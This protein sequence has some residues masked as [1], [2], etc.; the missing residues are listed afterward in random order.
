MDDFWAL[1]LAFLSDICNHLNQ[2]NCQ[3]Q[4]KDILF[5]ESFSKLQAFRRK[6]LL[7]KNQFENNDYTNFP[8]FSKASAPEELDMGFFINIFDKLIEE[9][10]SRFEDDLTE[11]FQT[12]SQFVSDPYSFPVEKLNIFREKFNISLSSMQN[13]L[14]ELQSES[15][16]KSKSILEMWKNFKN[17]PFLQKVSAKIFSFFSSTYCCESTFSTLRSVITLYRSRILDENLSAAI[18]CSVSEREPRYLKLVNEFEA[19]VSN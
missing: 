7:Y 10:N 1:K 12:C 3:L 11:F 17:Y 4:G 5:H 16:A 13:E 19:H 6:L 18:I 15:I 8:S 14:I 2:L 9:F